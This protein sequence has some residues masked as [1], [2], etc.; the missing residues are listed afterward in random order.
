MGD[1]VK[2]RLPSFSKER[3]LTSFVDHS[4][5][6]TERRREREREREKEITFARSFSIS[7]K[8]VDA[9]FGKSG[10]YG[11]IRNGMRRSALV[12]RGLDREE[13]P[14]REKDPIV[15][16]FVNRLAV[17]ALAHGSLPFSLWTQHKYLRL[18]HE[19]NINAIWAF[20]LFSARS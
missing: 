7:R 2:V 3:N 18:I 6:K 17:V 20:A 9:L 8:L 10:K 12:S 14:A 13:R 11:W 16:T 5:K 15:T 19:A 4:R 1:G